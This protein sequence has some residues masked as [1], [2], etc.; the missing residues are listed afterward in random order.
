[1]NLGAEFKR[2]AAF[3]GPLFRRAKLL[4]HFN[5]IL[6]CTDRLLDRWRTNYTDPKAVHFNMIEQ[7]QQLLLAVF[8]YI[9]FD[10]DLQTLDGQTVSQPNELTQAFYD[11]VNT[12][13]ILF[14]LPTW[15]GK[16][17]MRLNFKAQRARKTIDRY[18]TSMIEQEQQATPEM[19]EQ[20]KRTSFI[21]SLVT[22]LQEDEQLEATKPEEEK[23]G[24]KT[25]DLF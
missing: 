4:V 3:T 6:D 8:G 1:M 10:Y 22:S 5:T 18:L 13:Q 14:V 9:A 20:R 25:K 11:L 23:K 16:I 7:S 19:T 12:M 2:H 24:R 15:M 17:F 21:A